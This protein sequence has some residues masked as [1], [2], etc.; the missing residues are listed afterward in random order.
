LDD[1]HS[2]IDDLARAEKI[3][4]SYFSRV[5]SLA[6]PSP[7]IVEAILD[8]KYPARLTTI[9]LMNPFPLE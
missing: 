7:T 4:P 2:S 8:E 3:T 1:T 6:Y 5:L 9:D